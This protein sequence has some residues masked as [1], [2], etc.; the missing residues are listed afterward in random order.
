MYWAAPSEVY[1]QELPCEPPLIIHVYTPSGFNQQYGQD[2]NKY[3]SSKQLIPYIKL[4][5][6][7]FFFGGVFVAG[8][9]IAGDVEPAMAAFLRF[10]IATVMLIFIL[11]WKEKR[12]P[13]PTPTQFIGLTALGLTGVLGYNLCLLI[14]LETVSSGR[15]SVIVATNPVF[16]TFM[17]VLFLGDQLT[18]RKLVGIGLSV[19]GAV[20]VAS[21]GSWNNLMQFSSGDLSILVC[22]ICWASYSVIGKYVLKVG[23]FAA[24]FC[25]VQPFGFDKKHTHQGLRIKL[26]QSYLSCR[27]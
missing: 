5:V 4:A 23:R 10:A 26:K 14:G 21:H 11:L 15:S 24:T 2:V 8:R 17:S 3:F 16:I 22:A 1:L 25:A 27:G 6:M 12:I 13:V 9:T 18:R 7:S 20:L 19:S